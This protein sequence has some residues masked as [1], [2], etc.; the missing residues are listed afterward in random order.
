MKKGICLGCVPG[1]TVEAKMKLAKDAGYDGVEIPT[2]PTIAEAEQA[3]AIA[4]AVGLE[5]H[6][7][8]GGI[9]WQKP[10]SS[11]DKKTRQ[12]GIAGIEHAI[13]V[14]AATGAA[15]MLLV[16]GVVNPETTYEYA[17][18][19]AAKSIRKL[20]PRAKKR[21]VIIAVENVWNKFLLS[22]IEMAKFVD[23]FDSKWVQ[24]YFDVGNILLYGYP[25][26]WILSLGKRIK[27]VHVKDFQVGPKQFVH[28]LQGDVPWAEVMKALR[29]IKYEDYITV[30]LPPYK[31]D[32]KKMPYDMS[33]A[34]DRIFAM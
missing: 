33:E 12:E 3:K 25:Q 22:P 8:M 17:M 27:K 4:E 29:K 2:F 1:E 11:P 24:A 26:H 23:Q 31:D 6:S 10:L 15:T 34:L 7:V 9:H 30:E 28:L 13:D 16:P 5:I 14:A 18:K 32:P 20:L 21:K 19:E